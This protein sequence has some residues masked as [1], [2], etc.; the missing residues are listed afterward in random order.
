MQNKSTDPLV[1]RSEFIEEI[2]KLATK[3][4]LNKLA[5]E[6]I[7]IES[8]L[9]TKATKEDL[10]NTESRILNAIDAFAQK[11]ENYDRKAVFHDSRINDHEERITQLEK[12]AS[13]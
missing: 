11:A 12:T 2:D 3:E 5:N 1:T 9:E 6:I 8:D 7:K 10:S 13:K 4:G